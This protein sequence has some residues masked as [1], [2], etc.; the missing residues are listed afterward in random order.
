MSGGLIGRQSRPQIVPG[1]PLDLTA[2]LGSARFGA[3]GAQAA[4]MF[5]R[6]LGDDSTAMT[7]AMGLRATVFPI[8]SSGGDA[9]GKARGSL[10]LSIPLGPSGS[11]RILLRGGGEYAWGAYPFFEAA[12]L[13]GGETVRGLRRWR[14]A[15]DAMMF[16][17]VEGA[18]PL[19]RFPLLMN[20]RARAHLF[21]DAGRVFLANESSDTWHWAPGI[22]LS[23]SALDYNLSV[24]YAHGPS[25]QLHVSTGF[26]LA[27]RIPR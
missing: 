22:G 10:G 12:F 8:V 7:I 18:T 25:G 14:Y 26:P 17:G 5:D 2:P 4:A 9:Y 1:S 13:G 16:G 19:G 15:G 21:A 6:G 24:S 20:W 11:S 3:I 23:F 27:P